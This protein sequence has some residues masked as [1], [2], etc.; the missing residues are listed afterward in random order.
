MM[1]LLY[2]GWGLQRHLFSE[3]LGEGRLFRLW[4]FSIR[5]LLPLVMLLLLL[6]LNGVVTFE[7]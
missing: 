1:I 7:S 3:Q 2:S 6:S 4:W 5:Y